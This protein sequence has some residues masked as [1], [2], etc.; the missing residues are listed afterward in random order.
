[1]N[2]IPKMKP[3]QGEVGLGSGNNFL[4]VPE[5]HQATGKSETELSSARENFR[6]VSRKAFY[7]EYFEVCFPLKP[8]KG[9]LR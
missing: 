5:G 8:Q 3:T 2:S 7:L 9:L 6:C 4:I 1:M